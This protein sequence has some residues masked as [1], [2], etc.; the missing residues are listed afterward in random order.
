MTF[1]RTYRNLPLVNEASP[2]QSRKRSNASPTRKPKATPD[3]ST[4]TPSGSLD[5]TGLPSVTDYAAEIRERYP[6]IS[7]RDSEIVWRL[8][9]LY[10]SLHAF[11]RVLEVAPGDPYVLDLFQKV[12]ALALRHETALGLTKLEDPEDGAPLASIRRKV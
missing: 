8:A 1:A 2:T 12:S 6:Q 3:A 7:A 4:G 5:L 11:G 9:H 10:R